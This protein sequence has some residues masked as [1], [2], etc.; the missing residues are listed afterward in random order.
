MSARYAH[1]VELPRRE[2]NAGGTADFIS[3]IRPGTF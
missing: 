1:E 2:V 3:K